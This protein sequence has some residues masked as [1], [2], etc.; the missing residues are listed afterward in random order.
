[1]REIFAILISRRGRV[2]NHLEDLMLFSSGV[3]LM[4]LWKLMKDAVQYV[5]EGL[6][7]IFSPSKDEYP[8]SGLQ[9]FEGRPNKKSA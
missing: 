3:I 2:L 4:K 1:M 5:S 8:D 9:P 7:R 6:L